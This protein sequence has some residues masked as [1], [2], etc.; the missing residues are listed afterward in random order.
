MLCNTGTFPSLGHIDYPIHTKLPPKGGSSIAEL[1][2]GEGR[3]AVAERSH[4]NML[5]SLGCGLVRWADLR[6]LYVT[7]GTRARGMTG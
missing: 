5:S 1:H 2:D 6:R 7:Y 4:G 3:E